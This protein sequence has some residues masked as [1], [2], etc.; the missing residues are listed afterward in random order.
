MLPLERDRVVPIGSMQQRALVLIQTWNGGPLPVVE[1][2]AGID[3]HVAVLAEDSVGLEILD[4]DVVTS[5]V[6]VPVGTDN[7]VP[8]LDILLQAVLVGEV[9]KVLKD[10]LGRR[11]HCGPV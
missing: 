3:E 4:P 1:D 10:L 8:D 2:S 5:L 7:L 11:I 9:V 6:V